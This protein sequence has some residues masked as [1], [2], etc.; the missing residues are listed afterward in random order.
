LLALLQC[1]ILQVMKQLLYLGIGLALLISACKEDIIDFYYDPGLMHYDG[2]NANAPFLPAG[3]T[4]AAAKFPHDVLKL[5]SGK[6][7]EAVQLYIYDMP[8]SC[9]LVFY[10]SGGKNTPGSTLLEKDITNE[11]NSFSWVT[12]MLDT[13]FA[14][15]SSGDLWI[16]LRVN[17][18]EATQVIGC[19]AGPNKEGGDWLYQSDDGQWRTFRDRS[20]DDINW[21]IRAVIY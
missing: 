8:E 20:P 7:I 3:T 12:I 4:E 16:A 17:D 1:A 19:D 5:Y 6:Q 9:T 2:V 10:G 21:N 11:L 14:I 18:T 15:P 13:Q